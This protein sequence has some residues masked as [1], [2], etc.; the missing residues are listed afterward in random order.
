MTKTTDAGQKLLRQCGDKKV[1][2]LC[3]QTLEFEYKHLSFGFCAPV[4]KGFREIEEDKDT[5]SFQI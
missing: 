5:H 3:Y 4:Q 1:T 2:C